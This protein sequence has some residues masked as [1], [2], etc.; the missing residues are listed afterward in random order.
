MTEQWTSGSSAYITPR[1]PGTGDAWADEAAR[2]GKAGTQ[3]LVEVTE[4]VPPALIASALRLTPN[5]AAIVRRRVIELDGKPI[6]LADSYYPLHVASETALALPRKIPGGAPTLLGKLGYIASEVLED[7]SAREA[8]A[9][10]QVLLD[11]NAGDPVL[12][13]VR[14]SLDQEG[15]PMEAIHMTMTAQG[16]HLHYRMRTS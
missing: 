14:L 15:R 7:I 13:L 16:R 6:E 8:T 2:M 4:C 12:L 3:R 1:E 9:D 5:E 11:L 10:E